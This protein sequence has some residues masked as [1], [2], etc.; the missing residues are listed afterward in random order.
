M[1]SICKTTVSA[2]KQIYHNE[3]KPTWMI[4][5]L[6]SEIKQGMRYQRNVIQ[7]DFL[8]M[9]IRQ[10]IFTSEIME[11]AKKVNNDPS[12]VKNPER[13]KDEEV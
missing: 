8:E 1:T 4:N 6:L 3:L 10:S 11:T 12:R 2:I 13:N 7:K 9:C 5:I